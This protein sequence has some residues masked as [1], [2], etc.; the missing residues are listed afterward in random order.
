M[1]NIAGLFLKRHQ[2]EYH[3]ELRDMSDTDIGHRYQAS[4]VVEVLVVEQS[5]RISLNLAIVPSLKISYHVL[6]MCLVGSPSDFKK[7]GISP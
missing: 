1:N 3:S 6:M 4:L 5:K 7:F 2:C